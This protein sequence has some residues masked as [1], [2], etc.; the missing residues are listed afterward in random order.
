[1]NRL[2]AVLKVFDPFVVAFAGLLSYFLRFGNLD[3]PVNYRIAILAVFALAIL[4]LGAFDAY[5]WRPDEGLRRVLGRLVAGWSGIVIALVLLLYATKT[6]SEFSRTWLGVWSI[7]SFAG[8]LLYRLIAMHVLRAFYRRGVFVAKVVIAGA[9]RLGMEIAARFARYPEAGVRVVAFFDDAANLAGTTIER[10]PVRGTIDDVPRFLR[11]GSID[12]VWI[13]LPLRAEE[14]VGMLLA[15]LSAHG[16]KVRFV[17]DIFGFRLLNHSV[18]EV[19]GLPVVNL[20]EPPLA[21]FNGAL[22]WIEDKVIALVVLTLIWPLLLLLAV[23]VKVSSPG[24]VLFKQRR[25]GIDNR[26]IAIWKFR[27]MTVHDELSVSSMPQARRDDPRVT[28][29]GAWM[30]K[31]SLDELPQFINV[32]AGDMSI[33]GPRPHAS[34]MDDFY[35]EKIPK[36]VLRSW[37]KPGITG[38]A[39]VCGWRGETDELWKMEMRVQHD[40]Y[41]MENWSLGFDLFIVLMTVFRLKGPRA[42]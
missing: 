39:Q 32:L 29:F 31:T 36:Y 30:R 8:L 37:I 28:R 18:T 7:T 24:P 26:P 15:S 35:R 6:G 16:V 1:M 41:Y 5:H 22:K 34:W 21:G 12:Q 20:T 13:A 2:A 27:S 17:P 10:V 38:W 3:L 11:E 14:R 4:L 33:V 40:L 9:G 19:V 25:G 42:Y 23:A